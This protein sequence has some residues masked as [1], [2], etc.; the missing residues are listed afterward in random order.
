[1]Y[2]IGGVHALNKG[3]LYEK[4]TNQLLVTWSILA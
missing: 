4:K 1:M 2:I 3:G